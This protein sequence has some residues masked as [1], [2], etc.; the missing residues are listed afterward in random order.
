MVDATFVRNNL[1]LIAISLFVVSYAAIHAL[2]PG[3][4]YN[5]DG[6]LRQFGV[7]RKLNTVV[8]A[9]LVAIFMALFSYMATL[10]LLRIRQLV[11]TY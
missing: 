4:M 5:R 10:Y 9:W 11:K 6:S 3:F 2:K 7:G 8:P 1:V